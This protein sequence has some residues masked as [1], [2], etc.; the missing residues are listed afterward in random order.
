[1]TA[2]VL[3]LVLDLLA[4][5]PSQAEARI[6]ELSAEPRDG[7]VVVTLGLANAFGDELHER[8]ASGLPTGIA[9][10]L[11]LCR[12]RKRWWD[13]PLQQSSLQIVAMYNALTHEY[14]V[15]S[16]LDGR[17]IESREVYDLA[18]LEHVM[19]RVEGLPVFLLSE[20]KG[21]P[22]A[23]FL[24]R[25]RAELGSRTLLSFI[26]TAVQTAWV[27]SRKFRATAPATP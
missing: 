14:L 6:T 12:D 5:K 17:L 10:E 21:E 22:G 7:R 13:L 25:A 19:T 4:A 18:E 24:V 23:R 8:I 1:M 9:F 16:K 11:E 20:L 26:P 3:A 27:E 2:V 15:N